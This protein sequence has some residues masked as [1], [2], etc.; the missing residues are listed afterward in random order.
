M[1]GSGGSGVVYVAYTSSGYQPG[2]MDQIAPATK[3]A[4]RGAYSPYLLSAAYAGPVINLRRSADNTTSDFY[5]NTTGIIGQTANGL[6]TTLATWLGAST[7]YVAILYDQS[8]S[9][10]HATQTTA[11]AQPVFNATSML[12]DFLNSSSLYLVMPSNTVPAG[13]LNAPYT[14]VTKHGTINNSAGA[15]ICSGGFGVNNA[16]V[17]RVNAGNYLNY[18]YANDY[19]FGPYAPGNRVVVKYDSTNRIGYVNGVQQ[20]PGPS[21][22]Y[23]SL[24][25]PQYIGYDNQG[26]WL[27][28]QLYYVYIFGSAI[29]DADRTIL[30]V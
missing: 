25:G 8:G 16:N 18:W 29:P 17:L 21:S 23:T 19:G 22:G 24:A 2:V 9:G 11:A 7:A 20:T 28:G 26:N 30:A 14:F 5:A 13:V 6:G 27:N 15:L 4:C 3:A 1:A 12:I 10:N